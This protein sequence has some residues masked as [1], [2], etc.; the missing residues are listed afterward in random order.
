MTGFTLYWERDDRRFAPYTDDTQMAEAVMRGL[1]D[2]RARESDL[3]SVMIRIASNFAGWVE[4]PQGGHRSPGN[5]CMRGSQ[6]LA[7]GVHWREAGGPDAGGCGSVMRS[8]PFGLMFHDDAE[9]AEHWA[10]EHSRMTH[11][12]PIALAACAAMAR[13]VVEAVG[14]AEAVTIHARMTEAAGRWD[15]TTAGMLAEAANLVHQGE[16]PDGVLTH[17]QGWAAHEAI[18][19]AAY[20]FLRN[21]TN[22]PAGILEGANSEGD[23]DS[24]ATLAGALLGASNGVESLPAEWV[25]EVERGGELGDLADQVVSMA[26]S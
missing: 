24:I 3:D 8:Y 5:A 23:S 2:G 16:A 1:I 21:A 7:A 22:T 19:A 9:Q 17:W 10:V 26:R 6:E 20:V 14:G 15:S 12:A 25:A 4:H 11:Q 13:G 18:A